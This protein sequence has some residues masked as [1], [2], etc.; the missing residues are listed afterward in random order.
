MALDRTEQIVAGAL[1]IGIL[2]FVV[3]KKQDEIEEDEIMGK[4][5]D[6]KDNERRFEVM[7][8]ELRQITDNLQRLSK[9]FNLQDAQKAGRLPKANMVEER[10]LALAKQ[11]HAL[12]EEFEAIYR[13]LPFEMKEHMQSFQEE[14]LADL[15]QLESI[16]M[17]GKNK[18]TAIY[19]TQNI[20]QFDQRKFMQ[21]M[22]QLQNFDQ[23]KMFAPYVDQRA[24]SFGGGKME[25]DEFQDDNRKMNTDMGPSVGGR[26]TGAFMQGG[27]GFDDTLNDNEA[28]LQNAVGLNNV[29]S[30][31]PNTISRETT[32][33]SEKRGASDANAP[34][35]GIHQDSS[36]GGPFFKGP[37]QKATQPAPHPPRPTPGN[38]TDASRAVEGRPNFNKAGESSDGQPNRDASDRVALDQLNE[39]G[40]GDTA[41]ANTLLRR[42]ENREVVAEK[43]HAPPQ[44]SFRGTAERLERLKALNEKMKNASRTQGTTSAQIEQIYRAIEKFDQ[45]Y[46]F[47]YYHQD[48]RVRGAH[49]TAEGLRQSEDYR[50][51][52]RT[53]MSA[54]E[55]R[56]TFDKANRRFEA[57]PRSPKRQKTSGD[58][59]ITGSRKDKEL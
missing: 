1:I 49:R 40:S 39:E 57:P 48:D 51:W 31:L 9:D 50:E 4:P 8:K 13:T 46:S 29:A 34:H 17:L 43:Q 59:D 15:N 14:V 30:P 20:A 28:R 5:P 22:Q 33:L 47:V 35:K 25:L 52:V 27:D 36:F 2:Y 55:Y 10:A 23:R 37:A 45:N 32:H 41:E 16:L 26:S 18:V 21:H 19:N 38:G 56:A 44:Y 24:I 58:E 53:W 11:L 54:K 3:S 12:R 6:G 42:T 7:Q